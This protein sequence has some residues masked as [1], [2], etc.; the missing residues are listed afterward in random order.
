M[1]LRLGALFG[2]GIVIYAIMFLLW[3]AFVMYGFVEGFAPRAVG[4]LVLII[5]TVMAGRALRV[6]TWRDILPYSLSWGIMM[7]VFD[8]LMSV[9]L[10]GWEVFLDWNVWF[11]YA[12]VALGP[13]LALYP[14]F[15]RFQSRTSSV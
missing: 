14:R 9:P 1:G 15:E 4:F 13:L 12:V 5:T 11:G 2:W 10:A 7:A 3:S 8:G 6:H